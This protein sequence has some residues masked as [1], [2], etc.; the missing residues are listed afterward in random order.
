[1]LSGFEGQLEIVGLEVMAEV[2]D[3]Q[4][5]YT[6]GQREKESSV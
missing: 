4:G 1:M 3:C 2:S 5:W 6:F